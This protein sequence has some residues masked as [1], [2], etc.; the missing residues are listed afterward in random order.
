MKPQPAPPDEVARLQRALLDLHGARGRH[1]ESVAVREVFNG[2][3]VWDGAVEVF[4]L[5]ECPVGA[6]CAYA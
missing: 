3:V 1:R 5:D 2:S 6:P 4:D